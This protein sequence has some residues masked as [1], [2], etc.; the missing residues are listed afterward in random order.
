M[1]KKNQVSQGLAGELEKLSTL[2]AVSPEEEDAYNI[3]FDGSNNM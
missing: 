1:Q 2:L 3:Q